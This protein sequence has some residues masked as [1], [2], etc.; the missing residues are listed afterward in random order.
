MDGPL[1]RSSRSKK[2][3]KSYK[4]LN[5][6]IFCRLWTNYIPI[7]L[8]GIAVMRAAS[9]PHFGPTTVAQV[10]PP[11][12]TLHT[13][14]SREIT[15]KNIFWQIFLLFYFYFFWQNGQKIWFSSD[16]WS[17]AFKFGAPFEHDKFYFAIIA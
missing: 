8:I 2:S 15:N 11:F 3:L 1:Y 16:V 13:F 17:E 5:L 10:W 9:C 7:Y 12:G 6:T 4:K 14:P